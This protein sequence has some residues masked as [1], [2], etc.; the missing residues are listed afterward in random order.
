MKKLQLFFIMLF[1]AVSFMQTYGQ[2]EKKSHKINSD[3]SQ[4]NTR[5][6]S[7][8][9]ISL[10]A[11]Y[12]FPTYYNNTPYIK[13]KGG[14]EVGLSVDYYWRWIGAGIDVDY[15]RNKPKSN[16]PT[17]NLVDASSLPIT[18]FTLSEGKITRIFYGIGPD[19]KYQLKNGKFVAEINT[20][21]GLSYIKGG[22]TEL[23]ETTTGSNR[24]LNFHAGYDVKTNFSVKG[25]VRLTYFI[26]PNLGIQLG[27]YY[28]R[29][30]NVPE[31]SDSKLNMSA[32]Y[33]PLTD[34]VIVGLS[35]YDG[36][37]VQ[38]NEPCNC[39]IASVG[40]FAGIT[41]RFF[42]KPKEI[43]EPIYGLT[44]TARDKYTHEI[45]PDTKVSVKNSAG[46]IVQNGITNSFGVVVFEKMIPDNYQIS[47][48]LNEVELEGANVLKHEFN[49]K[50][51][52]Q[53]E[54]LYTDRNFIIKG[55]V[56]VC[57]TTTPIAGINVI[58]E[59]KDQAFKKSTVTDEQGNFVLQLPEAGTFNLY[60]KKENYFSQVETVTASNYSREKNLFVKL[61]ICSEVADCGKAIRLKNIL[62]DLD[63][64]FIR[65][66]AKPE[67]NKLVRFMQDNPEV[68][69]ELSSH[70]DC[71][72]T[73]EYNQTL[74]QNRAN[75]S[76][77]YVVSQGISRDRITGKGYGESKLLNE[78]ADGVPC[79]EDQHAINRRTE[80]KV[81]CK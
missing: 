39:D 50:K 69:V 33:Q 64:Y 34:A 4:E 13:Y 14:F 79:T 53:K 42:K 76:V 73:A 37:Q 21:V 55:R 31:K 29:H 46:I 45:L 16:Y 70:T 52:V 12:D 62:F 24:L 25:Q 58:L 18:S 68:K 57:N 1:V 7:Y 72:A 78:C 40:L 74:S 47:G 11:G 75:A 44:I 27:A 8:L 2:S 22:R 80:M 6:R 41:Y 65:E 77:D 61:E 9:F 71:R 30:F 54:I 51:V 59:N 3:T 66:S 17:T 23:R 60:G 10:R 63:K 26:I 36:P 28:L 35:T 19:F 38:R 5:R 48:S 15:I 56:F 32:L 20:R 67:L 43:C 81:I 49:N